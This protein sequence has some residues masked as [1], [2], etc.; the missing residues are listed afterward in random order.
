MAGTKQ[1]RGMFWNNPSIEMVQFRNS[2][3]EN[4]TQDDLWLRPPKPPRGVRRAKK[5]YRRT[6]TDPGPRDPQEIQK[7]L[8]EYRAQNPKPTPPSDLNLSRNQEVPN[9]VTSPLDTFVDQYDSPSKKSP[10]SPPVQ[11]NLSQYRV[12]NSV[13]SPLDKLLHH[14]KEQSQQRPNSEQ[15]FSHYKVNNWASPSPHDSNLSQYR[16]SNQDNSTLNSE[17]TPPT[18]PSP[19][20]LSPQSHYRVPTPPPSSP[21]VTSSNTSHV[22][23]YQVPNQNTSTSTPDV[24]SPT[25]S[26]QNQYRV[27]TPPPSP[28]IPNVTSSDTSHVFQYQTP[29]QNTST[30]NSDVTSPTWSQQNQYRVPTPPPS[31]PKIPSSASSDQFQYQTPNQNSENTS[32]YV[33]SPT[34]SHHQSQYRVPTPPSSPKITP[35]TSSHQ[36]PSAPN[37]NTSTLNLSPNTPPST[38]SYL[39]QNHA[40][41]YPPPEPLLR[42]SRGQNLAAPITSQ[43]HAPNYSPPERSSGQNLNNAPMTG[44]YRTHNQ[45]WPPPP[46]SLNQNRFQV[47]H[48]QSPSGTPSTQRRTNTSR[49][50]YKTFMLF[51][52]YKFNMV[53]YNVCF[54]CNVFVGLFHFIKQGCGSIHSIIKECTH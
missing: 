25:W 38:S 7:I 48:S 2:N 44:Q 22:F 52:Y 16:V 43:N 50:K 34:S 13:A 41:N 19:S 9:S 42:H 36:Y 5:E 32:I 8:N 49:C 15:N 4:L 23:Q 39:S 29:S 18:S 33:T 54:V 31:S 53:C 3:L 47:P 40:P 20:P 51:C 17:V 6:N 35:P 27:P 30:S 12:S 28:N 24:T 37:R 45:T 21:N 10:S 14:Y 46:A 11:S 1:S 26:H